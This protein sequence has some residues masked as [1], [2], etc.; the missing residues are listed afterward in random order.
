ML[1]RAM[2]TEVETFLQ[3]LAR[4][5]TAPLNMGNYAMC[6]VANVIFSLLVSV[7]FRPDEARFV[8]L[9]QLIN[10]GF[11]LFNVAAIAGFIP[12]LRHLPGLNLAFNKIRVVSC[13]FCLVCFLFFFLSCRAAH[14][15][16]ERA[17]TVSFF[18]L[19]LWTQNMDEVGHFFQ[20]IVDEHKSSFDPHNIRDV[21]D[22]YILEIHNAKEEGHLESLFNGKDAGRCLF[23]C[24]FSS[25]RCLTTLG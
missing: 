10:E 16:V 13:L 19:L 23:V 25:R 12:V 17:L 3:N 6:A 2:Q 15:A 8:R 11:K 21:I 9:T 1:L 14:L 4:Q 5:R 22:S 7:R 18:L 24:F 20:N